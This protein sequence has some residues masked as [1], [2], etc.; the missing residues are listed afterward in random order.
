MTI[1]CLQEVLQDPAPELLPQV[2]MDHGILEKKLIRYFG[3]GPA[4][5][6]LGDYLQRRTQQVKIGNVISNSREVMY[7]VP[8]GSILGPL[9]FQLYIND[10]PEIV[11]KRKT[12][13]FA[14]DT[15]LYYSSRLP[16]EIQT[17]LNSDLSAVKG[18]LDMNRL[19]LN[20]DKTTF[21]IVRGR[22]TNDQNI[23]IEICN[24][25][26]KEVDVARVLGVKIDSKLT[27]EPH[28]R[29]LITKTKYKYRAFARVSKYLNKDMKV[30]LYNSTIASHLNYCDMVYE[31]GNKGM[32]D[33]LLKPRT[34][35]LGPQ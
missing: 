16:L 8:Q 31:T 20:A 12:L 26:V 5:K 13:M 24:R 6:L 3:N 29:N 35:A 21:M 2:R 27:Y 32:R 23:S 7:G 34:H 25:R 4:S 14:D 18:W 22:N 17:I 28:I 30:L 15:T 19:L 33:I 9:L 11:G 1:G 10:L